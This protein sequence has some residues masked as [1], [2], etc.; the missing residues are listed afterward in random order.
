MIAK[1]FALH[2]RLSEVRDRISAG[3]VSL[4]SWI[5]IPDSTVAEL[6]GA[7]GYDWVAVDME[8]GAIGWR[9]LPDL[10]RGIERGGTL[11]L[12]RVAEPRA[13]ECRRALDAGAGGVI[14]PMVDSASLLSELVAACRWPPLGKRGVGYARFNGFGARFDVASPLVTAPL[15]VAMIET[16]VGLS[17][18][19]EILEVGGLDAIMIGPYDL[20]GSLGHPGDFGSIAYAKAIETI[21]ETCHS[22]G[23]AYGIH[24]VEPSVSDLQRRVNEGFTFIAYSVDSVFLR[25]AAARPDLSAKAGGGSGS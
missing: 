25:V 9:E 10:F 18:L 15:V 8:H 7:A 20:S 2:D 24:V 21:I 11:P 4:G 23:M 13:I 6:V 1:A 14:I 12:V 5:Q 16:A 22:A 17:N 3:S 19:Q